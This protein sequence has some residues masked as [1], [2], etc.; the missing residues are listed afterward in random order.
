MRSGSQL[1]L[2]LQPRDRELLDSLAECAGQSRSQILRWSLRFY[3]LHG[4]WTSEAR[5]RQA[6]VGAGRLDVGPRLDGVA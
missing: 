4:P 3:C 6:V 2:A 5:E 1:I